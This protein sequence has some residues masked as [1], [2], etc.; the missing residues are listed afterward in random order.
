V[1]PASKRGIVTPLSATPDEFRDALLS[2]LRSV[3]KSIPCKFFYDSEG[4]RLFE[5]ICD[6]PEYYPTRTEISLLRAHSAEIAALAGPNVEIM[7]FGAGA[8][9]KIRIVLDALE[10]P[11]AYIPVDV[12]DFWLTSAAE[13]LASAYPR[14]AIYP[15][16]ADFGSRLRWPFAST[17]RRIG[18][19]PGSTIGN[20]TPVEAREFLSTTARLLRGGALLIGVDLVKDPA[21]LH[22]AYNDPA[23]VTAAFNRNLLARANRE[24]GADFDVMGFSHYAFYNP[25]EQRI[26]MHLISN[27][28]QSAILSGRPIHFAKGEALL[29]EYSYKYNVEEFQELAASAGFAPRALWCDSDR[30][31]SMHWLESQAN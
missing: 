11:R 22:A 23:G 21:I 7:E 19:F 29:T 27:V 14:I 3:P 25:G 12:S 4:S 6:L 28:R 26:E 8:G 15:V 18:F 31:F 13:R 24:L 30:L 17:A 16:T 5:Q 9:E 20:F 1:K 10:S 2:G